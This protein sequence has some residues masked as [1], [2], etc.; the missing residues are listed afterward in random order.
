MKLFVTLMRMLWLIKLL[1]NWDCLTIYLWQT[2]VCSVNL[3]SPHSGGSHCGLNRNFRIHK[4]CSVPL[5]LPTT[6]SSEIK[7]HQNRHIYQ[8]CL[9]TKSIS[10]T[11]QLTLWSCLSCL[12]FG[13]HELIYTSF[14]CGELVRTVDECATWKNVRLIRKRS[15]PARIFSPLSAKVRCMK[16]TSSHRCALTLVLDAC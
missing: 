7:L 13:M 4:K 9:K 6:K 14:P 12:D 5:I 10:I 15:Q 2:L 3:P 11:I 1:F 8:T 16:S